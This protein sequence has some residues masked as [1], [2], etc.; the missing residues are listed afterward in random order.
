M[1]VHGRSARGD[2]RRWTCIAGVGLVCV[3]DLGR[4][5]RGSFARFVPL[6]IEASR[7]DTPRARRLRSGRSYEHAAPRR[8]RPCSRP[9]S[10][11][12]SSQLRSRRFMCGAPVPRVR[13]LLNQTV[14]EIGRALRDHD[15]RLQHL[16]GDEMR[17][18]QMRA[19]LKRC[20]S[21]IPGEDG[22][23]VGGSGAGV[24]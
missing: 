11:R 21:L 18:E 14:E 13:G 20:M 10:V 9:G 8:S 1:V 15:T 3:T 4:R 24:R 17:A 7:R 16:L 19:E 23:A 6:L 2:P 12:N 22:S 5:G